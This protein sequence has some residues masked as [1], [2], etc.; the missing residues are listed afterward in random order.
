MACGHSFLLPD[1]RCLGVAAAAAYKFYAFDYVAVQIDVDQT[2]TDA[3]WD[4]FH[5]SMPPLEYF[6]TYCFILDR[7]SII[8]IGL[9]F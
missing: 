9:Y 4:I 8:V 3:V 1:E 5:D 2:G 6:E 7:I